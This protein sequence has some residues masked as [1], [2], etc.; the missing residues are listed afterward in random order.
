MTTL[1]GMP[2]LKKG[3]AL[4]LIT[5]LP[6]QVDPKESPA[7]FALAQRLLGAG[8]SKEDKDMELERWKKEMLQ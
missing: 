8:S 6:Q 1:E 2:N 7:V 3:E 4:D 5:C